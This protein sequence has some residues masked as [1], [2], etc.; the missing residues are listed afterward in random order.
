MTSY[1]NTRDIFAKDS[2]DIWKT[3]LITHDVNTGN[4][5]PVSQPVRRQSPEEHAAMKKI[6]DELHRVGVVQPSRSQWAAN[7]R[8]A[9]KKNR[10]WRMCIDFRDLN[11]RTVIH[12]PYPLPRFDSM[13]Y[14]LGKGRFFSCLDLVSGYD[15]RSTGAISIYNSSCR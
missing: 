6:V 2:I 15:E 5:K 12:D 14:A 11:K 10:S 3:T 4:A 8:M 9:K 1:R 13:L 7:V